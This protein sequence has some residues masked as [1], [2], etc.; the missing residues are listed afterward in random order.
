MI[1]YTL[2]M[3]QGKMRPMK[4]KVVCEVSVLLPLLPQ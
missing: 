1:K 3:R 4:M 2:P